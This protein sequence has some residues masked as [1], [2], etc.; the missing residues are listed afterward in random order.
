MNHKTLPL[1]TLFGIFL[2]GLG[3][4]GWIGLMGHLAILYPP[5]ENAIAHPQ[6]KQLGMVVGLLL[7]MIPYYTYHCGKNQST[8]SINHTRKSPHQPKESVWELLTPKAILLQV[9]LIIMIIPL[10]V[11]LQL[12][13]LLIPNFVFSSHPPT[14]LEK[15]TNFVC[16][17]Y[18]LTKEIGAYLVLVTPSLVSACLFY[19]LGGKKF[20][21]TPRFIFGPNSPQKE[22]N[23]PKMTAPDKVY[24]AQTITE[25]LESKSTNPYAWDDLIST[26]K[27]NKTYQ[28]ICDYLNS[29]QKIYPS[30]FGWCNEKGVEK[31]KE[32]STLLCSSAEEN[33]ILKFIK[34]EKN[35]K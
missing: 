26:P 13:F 18:N 22:I 24:I 25:F 6:I 29:T 30:Q 21:S 17:K 31:L 15:F 12:G 7:V 34:E 27:S 3:W 19:L 32:L 20:L 1:V 14:I 11:M 28:T 4:L 35:T 2:F 9:L 8:K 16:Q 33:E 23:S 5:W 10:V